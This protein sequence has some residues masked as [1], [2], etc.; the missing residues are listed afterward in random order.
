MAALVGG[1]MQMAMGQANDFFGPGGPAQM[2]ATSAVLTNGA[3]VVDSRAH[4]V[5]AGIA[6][7]GSLL[8]WSDLGLDTGQGRVMQLRV[9]TPNGQGGTYPTFTKTVV[10]HDAIPRLATGMD[11]SIRID[12]ND[13]YAILIV[14]PE[15]LG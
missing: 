11:V 4:L 12:P 10:P 9:D 13:P 15:T 6:T 7:R 14:W 3:S 1:A 5:H 8:E 2:Y